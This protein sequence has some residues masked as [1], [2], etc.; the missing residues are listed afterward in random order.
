MS[1]TSH[2]ATLVPPTALVPALFAV[3][4]KENHIKFLQGKYSMLETFSHTQKNHFFFY[5]MYLTV[6]TLE[7]GSLK[8]RRTVQPGNNFSSR[9]SEADAPYGPPCPEFSPGKP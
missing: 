7:V 1:G 8:S 9:H 3:N 4:S 2:L 6:N 5:Y